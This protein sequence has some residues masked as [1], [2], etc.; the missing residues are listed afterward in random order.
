MKTWTDDEVHRLQNLYCDTTLYIEDLALMVNKT[1]NAVHLK[2]NRL[3]LLRPLNEAMQNPKVREGIAAHARLRIGQRNSFFGK[4]HKTETVIAMK[5]KLSQLMSGS[6]N[7]FFGKHHSQSARN[8]IS[9]LKQG[10]FCGSLNPAWKGGYEPYYGPN[11]HE[12]RRKALIRDNFTCQRCFGK[13][14]GRLEVHHIVPFRLFRSYIE[15]N[16]LENLLTHCIRC[17]REVEWEV[18]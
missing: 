14:D 1:R 10:M 16:R 11:W 3:G 5:H 17:H 7:P 2:A 12:Q 15:A 13:R 6:K 4:K 18:N 8:Q 9:L